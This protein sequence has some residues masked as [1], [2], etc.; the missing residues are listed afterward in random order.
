MEGAKLTAVV[1]KFREPR[2]NSRMGLKNNAK[3]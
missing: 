3:I 2:F 1:G